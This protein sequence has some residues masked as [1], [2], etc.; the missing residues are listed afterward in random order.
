MST[1]NFANDPHPAR[2]FVQSGSAANAV[3]PMR[4]LS[5]A[6]SFD[7]QSLKSSYDA[8]DDEDAGMLKVFRD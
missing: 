6:T 3:F 5:K 8:D 2:G 4:R 1:I 7:K